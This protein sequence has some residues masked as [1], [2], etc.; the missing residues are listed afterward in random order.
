MAAELA[1]DEAAATLCRLANTN[2]ELFHAMEN[3]DVAVHEWQKAAEADQDED[4]YDEQAAHAGALLAVL[5][6][7]RVLLE[8]FGEEQRRAAEGGAA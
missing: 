8:V 5:Q 4:E 1:Q 6:A 2:D 3:L 7:S